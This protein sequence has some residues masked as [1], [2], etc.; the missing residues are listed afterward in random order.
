MAIQDREVQE[1]LVEAWVKMLQGN[2]LEKL[3]KTVLPFWVRSWSATTS[4]PPPADFRSEAWMP[5]AAEQSTELKH[6]QRVTRFFWQDLPMRL[7]KKWV[8][9]GAANKTMQQI[10]AVMK[11]AVEEPKP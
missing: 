8:K 9:G 7:A 1:R 6:L 3:A 4:Q 11:S 10:R 2:D 5:P